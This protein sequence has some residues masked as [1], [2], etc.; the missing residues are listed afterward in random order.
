MRAF[1]VLAKAEQ[2]IR[3]ASQPR[4]HLE[5]ALLRW[6]H[7]RKLVPLTD[8]LDQ[9]GG[10]ASRPSIAGAGR[11]TSP[12]RSASPV[13]QAR[14][15]ATAPVKTAAPPSRPAATASPGR[16]A[17]STARPAD[18]SVESDVTLASAAS[19]S[20]S[21]SAGNFK[22]ALLAE[23]RTSRGFLYNTVI[24]QAQKIEVADDRVTFTFLPAHR[25]L[26]EQLESQRTWLETAAE[27]LSG[28]KVAVVAVQGGAGADAGDAGSAIPDARSAGPAASGGGDVAT[29]PAAGGATPDAR[30]EALASPAVRDLLDV[31]PAEIRNVEEM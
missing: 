23:I 31:F 17:A 13:A 24:A 26:R 15:V 9:M 18:R 4:Y 25:A 20:G 10:A 30:R 6:M 3:N 8:L 27:R 2:D 7:L 14:P 16:S 28:R 21:A 1:D 19:T 22:D 12:A 29:T 11:V 5:M